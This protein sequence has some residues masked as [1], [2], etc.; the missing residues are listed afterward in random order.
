MA[1]YN[2]FEG[3]AAGNEQGFAK[4]ADTLG[5]QGPELVT[6]YG[7]KHG[8]TPT[9]LAK[10]YNTGSGKNI[11]PNQAD[12][13]MGI[14]GFSGT[15]NTDYHS[16]QNKTNY[17]TPMSTEDAIKYAQ[18]LRGG[19]TDPTTQP[20][21]TQQPQ[22]AGLLTAPTSVPTTGN[23][24]SNNISNYQLPA[25]ASVAER[26]TTLLSA[27]NPFIQ[28]AQTLAAQLSNRSGNLNTSMASTAGTAAAI[29]SVL[30][31]AQQDAN[32]FA[33]LYGQERGGQIDSSLSSQTFNQQEYLYKVQGA[34]SAELSKLDASQQM[35]LQT[36][37][38]NMD[39]K[40]AMDLAEFETDARSKLSKQEA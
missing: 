1:S 33:S 9:Q 26:A 7:A 23:L 37:L 31:I 13:M 40:T 34:I 21:P 22:Q 39:A 12:D 10:F 3:I 4:W 19:W 6:A 36:T 17:G 18:G 5:A 24:A 15:L 32:T 38:K 2:L 35:A 8:Y 27:D 30:P 20:Q 28:R 14:P 16:S 29:D 11:D 25:G